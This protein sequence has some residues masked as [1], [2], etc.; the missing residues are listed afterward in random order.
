MYRESHPL[1]FVIQHWVNL[2]SMVVLAFSGFYIHYPFFAGSMGVARQLHFIAMFVLIVNLTLRIVLALVIKTT[3]TPDGRDVDLD[4]KNWLPQKANRH[5]FL[6]TIKYYLF[7]R[8]EAVIQGKYNP[9]QKMAYVAIVPLVYIQAYTG[10]AL[11]GP[12]MNAPFFTAGVDAVGGL[13]AMRIIHYFIM[14]VFIIFTMI[15]VYL[16]NIY[17]FAPSK[18]MFL[19]KETVPD[20]H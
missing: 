3:Q 12:T 16:A 13:M 19:W 7:L 14:W 2:I 20:E 10:F 5:Q 18:M 6:E 17:G 4:I 15:H 11:Y 8:K 1:V 9:M